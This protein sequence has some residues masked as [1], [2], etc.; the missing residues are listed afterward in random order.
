[1]LATRKNVTRHLTRVRSF[2]WREINI[3]MLAEKYRWQAVDCYIQEPLACDSDDEK[4]IKHAVKENKALKLEPKKPAKPRS[5]FSAR[6]QQPY[7]SQQNFPMSRRVVIPA[8]RPKVELGPSESCFCCGRS[9][10]FARNCRA[11]IPMPSAG[12]TF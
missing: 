3:F 1:M 2:Y 9:G 11:P 6:P 4:R 5:Q 8:S 12:K 7:N 10:H